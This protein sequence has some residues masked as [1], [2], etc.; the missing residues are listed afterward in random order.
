MPGIKT[1]AMAP[2][3]LTLYMRP[4]CHLC[5]DMKDIVFPVAAQLGCTVEQRDISSD[6]EL[7]RDFGT[8]IPVLMVN[9]RKAFKHR[10]NE[11]D[12]RRRLRRE[13]AS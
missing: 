12:L 5:D 4:G 9:G 2:I 7:E 13:A 6:P 1:N 10:L 11:S 3:T 8:D